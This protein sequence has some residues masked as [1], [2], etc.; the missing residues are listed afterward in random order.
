[1][2]S[3]ASPAQQGR[4]LGKAYSA[5]S[6]RDKVTRQLDEWLQHVDF[7]G[8]DTGWYPRE[9]LETPLTDRVHDLI[10][11]MEELDIDPSRVD[12]SQVL[13]TRIGAQTLD[14]NDL[15]TLIELWIWHFG[16][17]LLHFP[18]MLERYI[19]G[20]IRRAYPDVHVP[21]LPWLY[22]RA[23]PAIPKAIRFSLRAWFASIFGLPAPKVQ[24][25]FPPVIQDQQMFFRTRE[26]T[27]KI[28]GEPA[29]VGW[30]TGSLDLLDRPAWI[31]LYKRLTET[32]ASATP[33]TSPYTIKEQDSTIILFGGG[34]MST[35]TH[36]R[37]RFPSLRFRDRFLEKYLDN[38][39]LPMIERL[40]LRTPII[41]PK[42]GDLNAHLGREEALPREATQFNPFLFPAGEEPIVEGPRPEA[43]RP[44]AEPPF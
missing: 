1:M 11:Q 29:S 30:P 32:P 4:W 23:H 15:A 13:E 37:P 36:G 44:Q 27:K 40:P 43:Q 10:Q 14:W 42:T 24:S 16:T 12:L 17:S 5:P 18:E 35:S 34:H 21:S 2:V 3:R 20:P 25:T 8:L 38:L 41:F 39:G 19:L 26:I 31:R 22:F 6:A 33:T 7:P 9:Y 28:V